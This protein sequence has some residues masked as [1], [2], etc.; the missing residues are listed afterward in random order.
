MPLSSDPKPIFFRLRPSA[1]EGYAAV[2]SISGFSKGGGYGGVAEA[3]MEFEMISSIQN[4]GMTGIDPTTVWRSH[5][6]V[7]AHCPPS[8]KFLDCILRLFDDS[9]RGGV[10]RHRHSFREMCYLA[11]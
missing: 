5:G 3:A 10:G 1:F 4:S 9:E 2:P 6:R 7:A 8:G 11:A